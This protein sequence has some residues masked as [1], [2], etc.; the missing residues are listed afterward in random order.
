MN[1]LLRT[2]A[3]AFLAAS[4]S[5]AQAQIGDKLD[6]PREVTHWAYFA[7]EKDRAAF[8]ESVGALRYR[9]DCHVNEE[10]APQIY[11][12]VLN[13]IDR[14]DENSINEVVLQ[15]FRLAN[16]H[17]GEYDGWETSVETDTPIAEPKRPWWKKLFSI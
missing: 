7:E 8:V 16:H 12:A 10:W 4:C 2:S 14:V 13:R 11:A 9:V 5:L 3:L 6:K 17:D 1:L 15:L